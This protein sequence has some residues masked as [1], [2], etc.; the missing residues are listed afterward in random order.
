[1][2]H[3]YYLCPSTTSP[4]GGAQKIYYHV[5]VLNKQGRSAFVL[6][7]DEGFSFPW[8]TTCPPQ[9]Y[10]E[11]DFRSYSLLEKLRQ[12]RQNKTKLEWEDLVGKTRLFTYAKGKKQILPPLSDEDVIVIPDYLTYPLAKHFTQIPT[13]FLNLTPYFIFHG[14]TVEQTLKE[15]DTHPYSQNTLG[16]IVGSKNSEEYIK[17]AFPDLPVYLCQTGIDTEQFTYSADKKKLIS[18]MPRRC[19][20]HL[21]QVVRL[22]QIRQKL[23]GWE[24]R[25]LEDV[26]LSS[27]IKTFQESAIYLSSSYQEGFGMPPAEAMACGALVVGYH[28]EAGKEYLHHPYGYP[29]DHGNIMDYVRKVEELAQ[30]FEQDQEAYLKIGREA[31]EYIRTTYTLEKEACD[32]I[33]AWEELALYKRE[34]LMIQR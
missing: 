12:L 13:V 7:L 8:K 27:I 6:H 30:K 22:L 15:Q 24:F 21:V 2:R 4:C 31:S 17:M 1:M 25:S 11:R 20:T 9:A 5:D 18:F 23:T 3:I 32:I 34:A 26:P 28:G 10:F 29:I 14:T 33:N 19:V 16:C